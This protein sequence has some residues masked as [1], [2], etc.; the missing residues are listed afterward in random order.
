MNRLTLFAT[1]AALG[2]A[3]A[4]FASQEDDAAGGQHMNGHE[5]MSWEAMFDSKLEQAFSAIDADG[6]GTISRQEWGEWQAD[7][8]FYAERF[9]DFDTDDDEAVDFEEYH[10]AAT[11]MYDVSNLTD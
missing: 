4:A 1:A 3:G 5:T 2:L 10:T 9:D 7:E 8:G 11:A 6:N